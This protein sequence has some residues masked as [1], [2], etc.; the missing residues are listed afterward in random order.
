MFLSTRVRYGVR[1]LIELGMNYQKQSVLLK[2]ISKRQNLSLKYLD[3]I[4]MQLKTKGIIK[5]IKAKKGGYLLAKPPEKITLYE[6]IE[7]IEGVR[8]IECLD[9]ENICSRSSHCGAR[10]VW[11][12]LNAK[13]DEVL[14]NITLKDFIRESKKFE[15]MDES[16]VFSV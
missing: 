4:F 14:K 3:H 6:I 16:V 5:K 13:V 7:A 10:I 1:A 11:K 8:R 2:D 9:D 12:R 15:Q